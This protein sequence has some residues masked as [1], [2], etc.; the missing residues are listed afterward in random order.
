MTPGDIIIASI[1]LIALLGAGVL[2]AWEWL[3]GKWEG[4]R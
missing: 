2:L 1:A 4:N 3:A